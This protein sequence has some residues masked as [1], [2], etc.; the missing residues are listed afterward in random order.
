[1]FKSQRDGLKKFTDANGNIDSRLAQEVKAVD[2]NSKAGVFTIGH[3]LVDAV[4]GSQFERS[5]PAQQLNCQSP[6]T[7]PSTKHSAKS[8]SSDR[9]QQP[10]TPERCQ[11]TSMTGN[12]RA[13][14]AADVWDEKRTAKD[15]VKRPL[16]KQNQHGKLAESAPDSQTKSCWL[17]NSAPV[18]LDGM[19]MRIRHL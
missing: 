1:M 5:N 2:C 7:G 15:T 11:Y 10:E 14:L 18:L 3:E 17:R 13:I 4:T 16:P 6:G 19:Q 9:Q 8:Q 12:H